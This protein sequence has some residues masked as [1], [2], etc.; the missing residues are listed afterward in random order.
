MDAHSHYPEVSLL[1][2]E[3]SK[4]VIGHFKALFVRYGIPDVMSDNGPQFSSAEFWSFLAEWGVSQDTSSPRYPQS[5]GLSE[6][7]VQVMKKMMLKWID[8]G[9]DPFLAL[10]AY[11]NSLLEHVKSLAEL[12]FGR[13]LKTRLPSLQFSR[14]AKECPPSNVATGKVLPPLQINDTVHLQDMERRMGKRAER[15]IVTSSAGPRYNNIRTESGQEYRRNRRHLLKTDETFEPTEDN[16]VALPT[17][18]PNNE[19]E[20]V[21]QTTSQ[22]ETLKKNAPVHRNPPRNWK[23]PVKLN[24][25]IESGRNRKLRA[26]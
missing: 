15:A 8:T 26:E 25:Y 7:A 2:S 18:P 23:Q 20:P 17:R 9:E 10:L 3:S 4:A 1:H 13:K 19:P 16:A 6:N 22:R 21:V 14:E 5:N 24:L 12:M 11:R